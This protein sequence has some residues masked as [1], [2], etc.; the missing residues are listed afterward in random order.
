MKIGLV[1]FHSFLQPGGVKNHIINLQKEFKRRRIQSKIIVPRRSPEERYGRDIIF[2][3]TS[4]PFTVG[5]TQGDFVVNF[6]PL[7]VEQTFKKEKFS[8]LHFL[9]FGFPSSF[10]IL[11]RSDSLNILTFHANLEKSEFIKQGPF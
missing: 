1:S 4:F 11:E 5:G 6:N 8:I 10:Q 2:L 7:A 9:N 3:G